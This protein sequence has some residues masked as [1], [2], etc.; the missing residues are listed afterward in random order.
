MKKTFKFILPKVAYFEDEKHPFLP[1]LPDAKRN[2]YED[3]SI[4]L[5]EEFIDYRQVILYRLQAHVTI[6]CIV[7]LKTNKP[8]FHLIYTKKAT[9]DI[10]IQKKDTEN[11]IIFP[12]AHSTF[13]YIPRSKFDIHLKPG[14]YLVYGLLIDIGLVRD[15]IYHHGHFLSELKNAKK[16]D[17]TSL[18]QTALWPIKELTNYQLNRIETIFFNYSKQNEARVIEQIYLLFDIAETKQFGLYEKLSE[19]EVLAKKAR[20]IIYD[21]VNQGFQEVNISQIA[22][23]LGVSDAYLARCHKRYYKQPLLKYRDEILLPLAKDRL[24][25]A[26]TIGEVANF[27]GFKYPSGFSDYF[28]KRVGLYPSEY[29]KFHQNPDNDKNQ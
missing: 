9:D 21:I 14:N 20:K 28:E 5:V 3:T 26:Y 24:L 4:Q 2:L 7:Q 11:K 17:K 22:F 25:S 27:C 12:H 29:I 19:G 13:T 6:D 15:I 18:Y 1:P 10:I 16:K 23:S 8:D